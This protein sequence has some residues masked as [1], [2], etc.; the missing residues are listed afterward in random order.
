[1]RSS[2]SS[3][4]AQVLEAATGIALSACICYLGQQLAA[5]MGYP[6]ASISVITILTVVLATCMPKRLAPLVPSSEGIAYILLQ[7]SPPRCAMMHLCFS[8]RFVVVL[9]LTCS[10]V[11][12]SNQKLHEREI[13]QMSVAERDVCILGP[14]IFFAAVGA[15]GEVR[16]VIQTAPSLFVFCFLQIAVHLLLILGAGRLAGFSRKEL[17]L[18]SNANVGG[19]RLFVFVGRWMR[20]WQVELP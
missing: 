7:V 18:A 4:N 5:A 8:P 14:Q 12:T 13:G 9:Q 17:L 1:M 20:N 2:P 6:S 3:T 11:K 15:A 19:R 10:M 16:A